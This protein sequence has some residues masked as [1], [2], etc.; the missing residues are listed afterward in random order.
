MSRTTKIT[1]PD[2]GSTLV[3]DLEA[4]VIVSHEPLQQETKKIDF[5]SKLAQIEHE[6][7]RAS[8]RMEEAMRR[9]QSKDRIMEDR[10]QQ[11][12]DDAKAKPITG[13]PLRDIDL[14]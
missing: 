2:C 5:D 4:G 14:D 10:F 7:N 6:R 3:V 12:M 9:E 8:D 1:C 13:K 11:L